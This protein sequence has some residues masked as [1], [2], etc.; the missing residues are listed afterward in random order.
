M[1]ALVPRTSDALQN[2]LLLRRRPPRPLGV[3]DHPFARPQ[4]RGELP[5]CPHFP[6]ALTGI[7]AGEVAAKVAA[8]MSS[9]GSHRSSRL[10]T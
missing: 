2:A 5:Q 6:L 3:D 4:I 10:N 9:A 8:A 7:A 1:K